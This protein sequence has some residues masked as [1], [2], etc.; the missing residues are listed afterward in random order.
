MSA[1]ARHRA[2]S[3]G[4]VAGLQTDNIGSDVFWSDA[5]AS[6]EPAAAKIAIVAQSTLIVALSTNCIAT[7]WCS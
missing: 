6:I 3:T 1:T 5:A 4:A 2:G 7:H